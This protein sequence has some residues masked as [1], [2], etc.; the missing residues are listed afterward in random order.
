MYTDKIEERGWKCRGQLID[1]NT[2]LAWAR[3]WN[4]ISYPNIPK[5]EMTEKAEEA[6]IQ[7]QFIGMFITIQYNMNSACCRCDKEY[8][9]QC[10][11]SIIVLTA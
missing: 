11:Y 7:V 3:V 9:I 4:I 10:A 6:D 2:I 8:C 1:I 5:F